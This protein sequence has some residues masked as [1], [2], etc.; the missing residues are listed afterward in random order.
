MGFRNTNSAPYTRFEASPPGR[1]RHLKLPT[2]ILAVGVL[3]AALIL[4]AAV[5]SSAPLV[6]TTDT[7]PGPTTQLGVGLLPNDPANPAMRLQ[8]ERVTTRG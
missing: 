1:P 6:V 8:T 2:L 7:G 5:A 4:V 3:A